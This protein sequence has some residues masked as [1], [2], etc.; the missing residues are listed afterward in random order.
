MIEVNRKLYMDEKTGLKLSRFC[1][2]KEK[3]DVIVKEL[4]SLVY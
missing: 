2:I 3:L 4:V 1:D